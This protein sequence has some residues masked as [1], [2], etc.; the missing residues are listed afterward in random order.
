MRILN[1]CLVSPRVSHTLSVSRSWFAGSVG[2][3]KPGGFANVIDGPFHTIGSAEAGTLGVTSATPTNTAIDV[4]ALANRMSR[5][6]IVITIGERRS[7]PS[8]YGRSALRCRDRA[9][10][11][12]RGVAARHLI[13]RAESGVR[14][15]NDA[16]GGVKRLR[17]SQRSSARVRIQG[18]AL[19]G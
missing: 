1:N 10:G 15:A 14:H 8:V 11:E 6:L 2:S 7:R 19:E 4:V 12:P 3:A 17:Q 9:S 16:R 5:L 13:P 18:H